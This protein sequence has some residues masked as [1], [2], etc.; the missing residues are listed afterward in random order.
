M[1]SSTGGTAAMAGR[2]FSATAIITTS[3]RHPDRV[4]AGGGRVQGWDAVTVVLQLV[5]T[6]SR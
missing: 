4:A 5:G 3:S 2:R 6:R 1:A